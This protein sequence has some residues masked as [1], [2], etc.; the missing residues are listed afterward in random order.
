MRCFSTTV[1]LL[2][3]AAGLVFSSASTEFDKASAILAQ[4]GE[5]YLA[6]YPAEPADLVPYRDYLSIDRIEGGYKVLAYANKQAFE[7]FTA[8]GIPYEVLQPPCFQAIATMSDYDEF[9]NAPAPGVGKTVASTPTNWYRYPTYSAY[10]QIMAKFQADYPQFAQLIEL[11]NSVQNRKILLLKVTANV[12]TSKG[13]PRFLHISM[14]HGDEL[15]NYMNSL[16]MID[17]LLSKYSTVPRFKTLLDNIEIWFVP[18]YNPDGCY[19]GGDNTVQS[20]QRYNAANVDIN[21]NYP[22]PCGQTTNNHAVTG[23]YTTR[24]P[25]NAALFNM[26]NRYVFHI[27]TDLHSG[28]ETM[29]WPYGAIS[30]RP[31]DEE[32]YKW[33][34]KRYADQAQLASGNSG[35]FKQCGGDGMG[36]IYSELYVCHGTS[37]DYSIFH[38]RG[39]MIPMETSMQKMLPETDLQRYWGYNREA[40]IQF[41]EVLLTGIQGTVKNAVT[42]EPIIGAKITA[43]SYDFD[44]A[45]SY[46]DSA[47]FYVRFIQ[48]GSR[49]MVY[50]KPGYTSKTVAVSVTDYARKYP[51]DVELD[52]VTAVSQDARSIDRRFGITASPSGLI[53]VNTDPARAQSVSIYSMRGAL[54]RKLS[55]GAGTSL[56]WQGRDEHGAL[57]TNGCYVAKASDPTGSCAAR[58]MLQR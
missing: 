42:K 50:S 22:C 24:Q 53:F 21:R 33:V 1:S 45:H 12:A 5:V 35:Y 36:N 30:R 6:I 9:L 14:V 41:Y 47:G 38:N 26:W 57:V 19:K 13:K 58:F 29:L 49:N 39:R 40:M 11:G 4:R 54:V 32:W 8:A 25:E 27:S 52:P 18:L 28:T 51:L 48:T 20:A 56:L 2:A 55:L 15:L 46:T 23:L 3:L 43:A 16:H 44:S 17:T 34:C 7:K 37:V 10:L 31:C